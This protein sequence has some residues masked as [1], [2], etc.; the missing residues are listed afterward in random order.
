MG[1]LAAT[2]KGAACTLPRR[3]RAEAPVRTWGTNTRV[4]AHAGT[5]SGARV[6]RCQECLHPHVGR[7]QEHVYDAAKSGPTL[8]RLSYQPHPL[9]VVSRRLSGQAGIDGALAQ[10]VAWCGHDVAEAS[11]TLE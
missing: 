3:G 5:L 1:T 8:I 9:I 6:R 2:G 4:R 7:C 11:H 10:I